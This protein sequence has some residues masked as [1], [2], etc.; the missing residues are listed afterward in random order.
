MSTKLRM[1]LSFMLVLVLFISCNSDMKREIDNETDISLNP[2]KANKD[3]LEIFKSKSSKVKSLNNAGTE[4]RDSGHFKKALDFHFRALQLGREINDT[5]GIIFALNNIGTDLR[6]TSSN[7]QA[8]D[9]HLRALELSSKS[10]K[11]LKSQAVAGNGLGNIYISLNKL[12]EAGDYFR[13]S[14]MIEEKLQSK[15]GKAINYAN[16]G[17]VFFEQNNLDSALYYYNKS[18]AENEIINSKI[19]ISLCKKSIGEIYHKQG[20]SKEALSLLDEA[21][22]EIRETADIFHQIEIENTYGEVL[23]NQGMYVEAEN[24]TRQVI[25]SARDIRSFDHLYIG[26]DLLSNILKKQNRFDDALNAKEQSIAYRDSSNAVNNEVRIFEIEN[27]FKINQAQE[28]IRLLTTQKTLIERDKANQ[29]RIFVL[30]TLLLLGFLASVYLRYQHRKKINQELKKVNEMKSRFFGNISHEFRTPLTLIKGP[31]ERLLPK[32]DHAEEKAD[33]E[34]MHRSTV[35]LLQLVDQILSLSKLD[36]GKFEIKARKGDLT[37]L[38]KIIAQSFHHKAYEKKIDYHIQISRVE[39]SWFDPNIVE[40]IVTNLLSNAFKFTK[41]GG[42][43]AIKAVEEGQK[44]SLTVS[45]S[46]EKPGEEELNR[47]FDLFYSSYTDHRQGTGIGLA[48]VKELCT[49]YRTSISVN[50]NNNG[51]LVFS[52]NFPVSKSHFKSDELGENN[53]T[54][55]Q[56]EMNSQLVH[57]DVMNYSEFDED[58]PESENSLPIMLIAEDDDDMRKYILSCFSDSFAIVEARNGREAVFYAKQQIPDIIISDIMMPEEDG[59]QVCK[60]LKTDIK[61]SHI[62]I[63]LLTALTGEDTMEKGFENLADDYVTKPFNFRIL[64]QKVSN[65]MEIRRLLSS[66]Y[67]EEIILRPLNLLIPNEEQRFAAVI[68]DVIENEIEN[69]LFDV[70]RFCE[71]ASMSRTQLLRKVKAL[72]NMSIVTFIRFHRVRLAS[73]L[74]KNPQLN[75]TDVCYASGFSDASYFSK[76]FREMMG[77]SPAEYRKKVVSIESNKGS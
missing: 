43:I 39:S 57:S 63:V 9:Y 46:N 65:L 73:E 42:N 76:T 10:D 49:L 18:L 34:M 54:A 66:K 28:Q 27:R 38:I 53:A 24:V 4:A 31:L 74:M 72:T 32:C 25:Q 22:S 33:L 71:L 30:S 62:P 29:L 75:I 21:I 56:P 51:E 55:D 7:N 6:R 19:G 11:Y 17:S 45:N 69:P 15:L 13:K 48:L 1:I 60:D 61:T 16:I 35:R 40:I 67:R 64:K 14:L 5:L 23:Y 3:S 68:K 70:D 52:V 44:Y 36:A 20:R 47:M 58:V 2:S 12:E 37:Q 59:L 26:Y 41:T 50:Y 77:V 8:A